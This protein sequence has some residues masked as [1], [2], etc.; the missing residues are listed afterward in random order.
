MFRLMRVCAIMFITLEARIAL[1]LH[2]PKVIAITGNLGKTSTKDAVYAAIAGNIRTR[3]SRKSF[4]SDIG[5][6]LAILGVGNPWSN[7]ILWMFAL[8]RGFLEILNPLFPKVLVLEVGADHPG[9]ISRIAAWLRPHVA[10]FT[11]VPEL[12]VHIENFPSREELVREKKSLFE[13]VRPDGHIVAID[14]P[15]TDEIMVGI[16]QPVSRFGFGVSCNILGS[17]ERVRYTDGMPT[18]IS[19]AVKHNAVSQEVRI[20]GSVGRSRVYAALAAFGIADL[21]SVGPVDAANGLATWEPTPGRMRVLKGMHGATIVDDSYNSSPKA[22]LSALETL[23]HLTAK[24]R[25]AVLGD[26]LEL[27][28]YS[29]SAHRDL[30]VHAANA[31]HLLIAVGERMKVAADA[32]SKQNIA[33]L[34]IV[35][36]EGGVPEQ[37]GRELATGLQA[38]DVV[39]VKGSQGMRL[40]RLVYELMEDK[41]HAQDLLV[42]FDRVW[43]K[44]PV[45]KV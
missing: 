12:P 43:R 4:N 30:G 34:K 16:S 29:E 13:H 1:F 19:F 18:S 39:L 11:G 6:P 42:R 23:S 32:A 26:M 21:L 7:P 45:S 28:T 33:A 27:G 40:E 41:K 25:I 14:D 35:Q 22:A 44:K 9:D 36:Y 5:V 3:K 10:V 15:S 24:R 37:V 17:E 38:G 2:R 20:F 8:L 31:C